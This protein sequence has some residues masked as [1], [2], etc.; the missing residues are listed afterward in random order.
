VCGRERVCEKERGW[1]GE[2]ERESVCKREIRGGRMWER[3][4]ESMGEGG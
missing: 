2:R 1:D 4:R 3:V